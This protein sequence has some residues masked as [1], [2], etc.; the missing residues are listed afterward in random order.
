MAGCFFTTRDWFKPTPE[1]GR[2]IDLTVNGFLPHTWQSATLLAV[3]QSDRATPLHE[4][5]ERQH[6]TK[7]VLTVYLA[8]NHVVG[9][10]HDVDDFL[11]SA[12]GGAWS[13]SFRRMVGAAPGPTQG[14]SGGP[15]ALTV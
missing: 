15:G 2:R 8:V 4:R 1:A 6:G 7:G 5:L 3:T 9:S 11:R 13:W 10:K 12:I 14:F